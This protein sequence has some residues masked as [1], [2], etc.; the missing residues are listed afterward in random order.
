MGTIKAYV[1]GKGK[2]YRV[3]YRK[4]DH[5]QTTKRG[6]RT[7]RE[8]E[9]YLASVEVK[10]ATGEYI[11][12]T[13][14]RVTVG[15]LG[16]PWIK[17]RAAGLKPSTWR[18]EEIAWRLHVEPVWGDQQVG[19]L[20]H[21]EVQAWVSTLSSGVKDGDRW[22]VKPKSATVVRR[23]YGILAGVLDSAV[24]DRCIPRNVARGVNLPRKVSKKHVYLTHEQVDALANQAGQ[25]ATLV[26]LLAYTGLRWGE[27]V[28]LRVESL[29]MLRRRISVDENAVNVGGEI[30]VGTPKPHKRRSVPFPAFLAEPLAALCEGKA[31]DAVLFGNGS[32]YIRTPSHRDGW[33]HYAKLRSGVPAKL[34]IHDLRHTA[35][36]LAISAGANVKAIQRMLGHASAAMTLDIYA[37]LFDDD[38]D[39]V[40]VALD[41]ARTNSNVV[42]MWSEDQPQKQAIS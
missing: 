19:A 4:P 2:R 25:Y 35:A 17:A 39:T 12:A 20:R 37:D 30:I 18:V 9:L 21:S 32:E 11:D 14:G 42:K 38:L 26:R 10:I 41:N 3:N 1:T 33:F 13:A 28:G 27:A 5:A 16:T 8:A 40:A 29:D 24:K 31:R 7:R 36:S 34:T 23:A 15:T 6:L 22:K